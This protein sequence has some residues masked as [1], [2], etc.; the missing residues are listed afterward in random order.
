MGTAAVNARCDEFMDRALDERANDYKVV[1]GW[2]FHE[3]QNNLARFANE[4]ACLLCV[5]SA[6]PNDPAWDYRL[7]DWRKV[8]SIRSRMADVIAAEPATAK[9]ADEL[10]QDAEERAIDAAEYAMGGR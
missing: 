6:P 10:R 5:A 3:I 2:V 8:D 1:R 7:A 4:I 9:L